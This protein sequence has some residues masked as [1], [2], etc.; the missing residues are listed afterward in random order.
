MHKFFRAG[1]RKVKARLRPAAQPRHLF[2]TNDN[3]GS[4]SPPLPPIAE[5]GAPILAIR[6]IINNE[7]GE[8]EQKTILTGL[9]DDELSV[10]VKSDRSPIP[11]AQDREL[12]GGD[13]HLLY[14]TLGL[15]DALLNDRLILKY[16]GKSHDDAVTTFDF[17][18]S[19]GRVLRHQ[20]FFARRVVF[21]EAISIPTASRSLGPIYRPRLSAC[22]T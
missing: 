17:G 7:L 21:S 15:G 19:S 10:H 13:N 18:C 20:I 11:A 8:T 4:L 3:G 14:W 6:A 16:L 5:I 9:T 12:Y 22:T 2:V 1:R